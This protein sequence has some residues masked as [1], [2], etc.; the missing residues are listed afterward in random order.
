MY[1]ILQLIESIFRVLRNKIKILYWKI[2]YGKRLKIGKGLK[3]RNNFIININEN[4]YLEIGEN[5]FFNN[6]CSINCHTFISIGNNN[7][8]GE[9][10]KIYDHNHVFNTKNSLKKGNFNTN[11][12]CIKNDNWVGSNTVILSKCNIGN[13]N[14]V[15]AGTIVNEVIEDEEIVKNSRTLE[16]RKIKFKK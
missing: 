10:V 16:K 4:G 14:V 12:I 13:C 5:N 2:K 3:F 8:F 1:R 9:N 6:Y 15:G 7:S 11:P